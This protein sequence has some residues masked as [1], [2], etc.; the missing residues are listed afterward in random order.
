MEKK[1]VVNEKEYTIKEILYVET[2]AMGDCETKVDK[3]RAMMRGC[4]GLTNEEINKLTLKEALE[5]QKAID[6][7]N[8]VTAFRSAIEE[9]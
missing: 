1:I 2:I 4:V 3:A 8:G 5:I 6:E 9:K 7:V